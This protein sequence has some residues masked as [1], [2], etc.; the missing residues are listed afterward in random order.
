MDQSHYLHSKWALRLRH[1]YV[2]WKLCFS[3]NFTPV[4]K[5]SYGPSY[6]GFLRVLDGQSGRQFLEIQEFLLEGSRCWLWLVGVGSVRIFW[7]Y[8]TVTSQ[9]VGWR[10]KSPAPRLFTQPF[11]QT[12]IKESIDAPR[13]WLCAGNSPMTGEFS[14]QMASNAELFFI[15]WRHHDMNYTRGWVMFY[16]TVVILKSTMDPFDLFTNSIQGHYYI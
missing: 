8:I 14:A 1:V 16:L 9:W 15:W 3:F 4:Y 6:L 10:L 13:H 2:T 11:I 7:L 5:N 12:Q